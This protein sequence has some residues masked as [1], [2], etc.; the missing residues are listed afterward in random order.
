MLVGFAVFLFIHALAHGVGFV[1]ETLAIDVDT[2]GR[3]TF[4]L[5]GL[6]RGHW[7]L[8]L[9]GIVWLL[10]GA[11]FVVAGIGVL[12]EADWTTPLLV[13]AT[14]ASTVLCLI[15]A[16]DTPFGLVA[17]AII[18]AVLLVPPLNDRV[19]PSAEES[20]ILENALER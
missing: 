14:V 6:E 12:Q 19:F 9:L 3:P 7:V 8:R 17:N 11:A 18:F 16:K 10:V 15:W 5:T 20:A 2:F 1:T 13:A 4:L